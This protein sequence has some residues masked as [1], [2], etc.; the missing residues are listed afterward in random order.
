MKKTLNYNENREKKNIE[1]SWNYLFVQ[2]KVSRE[3][4]SK[5]LPLNSPCKQCSFPG[6]NGVIRFKCS[7]G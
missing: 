2:L 1:I 4:F 6:N 5:C 7:F 3:V